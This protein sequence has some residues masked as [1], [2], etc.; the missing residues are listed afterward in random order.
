MDSPLTPTDKVL[1]AEQNCCGRK[2]SSVVSMIRGDEI[3]ALQAC[4]KLG[5]YDLSDCE[6]YASCEPCPMCFGAIHLSKLKVSQ[7]VTG[8]VTAHLRLQFRKPQTK[9]VPM[10]KVTSL[11]N[12]STEVPICFGSCLENLLSSTLTLADSSI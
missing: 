6:I 9:V 12:Q 3:F 7:P 1:L 2:I 8:P 4:R 10:M 5:R 11:R